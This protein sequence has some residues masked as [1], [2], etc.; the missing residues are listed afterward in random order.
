MIG[1]F[2]TNFYYNVNRGTTKTTEP[3][4]EPNSISS[5]TGQLSTRSSGSTPESQSTA[6]AVA[7]GPSESGD[8]S[9][10][11]GE[12]GLFHGFSMAVWMLV[13]VQSSMGLSVSLVLRHLDNVAK[14]VGGS[15]IL[16][17]VS[18]YLWNFFIGLDKLFSGLFDDCDS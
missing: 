4:A 16:F 11:F 12:N 9:G 2:G 8:K 15:A 5:S 1:Y 3:T 7:V 6:V 18:N 10:L 14:G 13:L 17:V